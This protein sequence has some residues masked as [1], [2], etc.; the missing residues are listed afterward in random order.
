MKEARKFRALARSWEERPARTAWATSR[1]GEETVLFVSGGEA[2]GEAGGAAGGE[3]GRAA[4]RVGGTGLD[5][6]G[7]S[8]AGRGERRTWQP[9]RKGAADGRISRRRKRVTAAIRQ[10]RG[11]EGI[12]WRTR[13][14]RGGG[15]GGREREGLRDVVFDEVVSR[16]R[17]LQHLTLQQSKFSEQ[18]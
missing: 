7:S 18:F 9:R 14:G 15:G 17:R 6:A 4:G 5:F 11:R 10:R 2:G 3:A 12:F 13:D 1:E 8:S 16:Q